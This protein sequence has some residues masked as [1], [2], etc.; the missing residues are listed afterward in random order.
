LIFGCGPPVERDVLK[1]QLIFLGAREN[2]LALRRVQ[3]SSVLRCDE[4]HRFAVGIGEHRHDRVAIALAGSEDG[5]SN[6]ISGKTK[7]W[8]I[9]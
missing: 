1:Q 8:T 6:W 2:V 7:Y 3:L 5:V 4:R 9:T